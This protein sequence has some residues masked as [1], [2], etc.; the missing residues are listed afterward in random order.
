MQRYPKLS[1]TVGMP[2]MVPDQLS[3]VELLKIF[4]EFQWVQLGRALDC[5]SHLL[6]SEE[7]ERLYASVIQVESRFGGGGRLLGSGRGW[8]YRV[9]RRQGELTRV[10]R[11]AGSPYESLLRFSH[12]ETCPVQDLLTDSR[13]SIRRSTL[14]DDGRRHE[15]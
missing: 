14:L 4:A 7:G 13:S 12:L 9:A 3:E 2:N 6:T 11:L 5:P 10:L 15:F 8:G 1:F